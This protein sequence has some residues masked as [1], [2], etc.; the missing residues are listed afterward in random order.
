M[1]SA[2]STGEPDRVQGTF[3]PEAAA[4][5]IQM[6]PRKRLDHIDGLR[7]TAVIMVMVRHYYM[8]SYGPGIPRWA[9]VCGLG[10]LGVHLFLLLS[11]FCLALACVR[12]SRLL[13]RPPDLHLASFADPRSVLAGWI[14][15]KLIE[16]RAGRYFSR[17]GG[18]RIAIIPATSPQI[19]EIIVPAPV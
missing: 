7:G 8:D 2:K 19:P 11:G 17:P 15:Y 12:P 4:P 9:D 3:E 14:Y 13:C 5:R 6:R 1:T 18:A 10:Y 16:E